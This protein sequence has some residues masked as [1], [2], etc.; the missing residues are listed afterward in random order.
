MTEELVSIS[1]SGENGAD[2]TF[3]DELKDFFVKPK[4]AS[5][6]LAEY[7]AELMQKREKDKYALEAWENLERSVL[8]N[9]ANDIAVGVKNNH[10]LMII[11]K[12]FSE[13]LSTVGSKKPSVETKQIY[14]AA[15]EKI[16]NEAYSKVDDCVAEL[17]LS[18]K[19]ALHMKLIFE[20][21]IGMI[22]EMTG[23]FSALIWAQKYK[24]QCALKFVGITKMDADKKYDIL[25]MST[26]GN[27]ALVHG[28]MGKIKDIVETGLLNYEGVMKLQQE[29]NGAAI[30]YGGAGLY[31]DLSLSTMPGALTGFMWSMNDYKNTLD[32][33]KANNTGAKEAWD[34]LEKSIVASLA[35]DIIVGVK[36]N[37]V[38]ITIVYDCI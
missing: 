23:D 18:N 5:W 21:T 15:D 26:S 4:A 22:R 17:D 24:N 34:E 11:T 25:S 1:S 10:I 35:K 38:E 13:A 9:L 30:N 37:R 28:L 27:N 12:D 3:L 7:E 19:D 2:R 20:E 6:S 29:Y 33:E 36:K 31:S 14:I 8:A 16:I 32:E